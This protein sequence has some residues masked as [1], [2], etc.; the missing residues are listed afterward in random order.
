MAGPE[1]APGRREE[2]S[3][4]RILAKSEGAG[5]GAAVGGCAGSN[6]SASSSDVRIRPGQSP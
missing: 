5:V 4:R 6:R 2:P 3:H 1:A